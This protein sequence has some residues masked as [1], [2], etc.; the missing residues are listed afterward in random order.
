MTPP[1]EPIRI[2][3]PGDPRISDYVALRDRGLRAKNRGEGVF[4]G[5]AV[6]VVGVMLESAGMTR[7][8]LASEKQASRM[9]EMISRSGSPKTP[10]FVADEEI[11]QSIAGFDLHRGVL[12]CGVRADLEEKTLEEIMPANGRDATLLICDG[13]SNIDNIG[14]LFRNAAAFGVDAVILS[15]DCHDPLY[16]KSLRV[17]IGHALRIPWHRSEDWDATLQRLTHEFKITL[18]GTSIE[19]K[20]IPLDRIETP[21]RVGVVMGS[22]FTGIGRIASDHCAMMTRIPMM[23]GTDSLNVGVASA[24]CLHK[25]SRSNRI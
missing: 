16:R 1:V 4:I 11:I 23:E 10:L 7:S 9:A 15:P 18:I 5:E 3:D 17:S 12:A 8:V 21:E 24:V 6:L 2:T 14:M 13:I 20:S 22:E 25:F 19:S